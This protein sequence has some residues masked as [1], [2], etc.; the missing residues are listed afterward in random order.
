MAQR[1]AVASSSSLVSMMRTWTISEC[2]TAAA[3]AVPRLQRRTLTTSSTRRSSA[4]EGV[5]ASASTSAY[6]YSTHVNV[7]SIVPSTFTPAPRTKRP[8]SGVMDYVQHQLRSQFDANDRLTSLFHRRSPNQ[9]PIGSVLIVETWS[10]PA[11]TGVTTFSGVLLGVRRRGTSTSFVLRNL[12]QKLG[13]EVRFNLYS[14]L[15]KDVRVIARA[16]AGKGKKNLPAGSIRRVRRAKLYY[17]RK[18]DNKIAGIGRMIKS[19]R[20]QDEKSKMLLAE[21]SAGRVPK[22]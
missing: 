18:D 11:K 4:D 14:P 16:D 1:N 22:Q 3:S 20:Q 10:S 5:G 12:V 7:P 9:I 17:L 8:T 2:S 21:G 6:P 13:V 15:L 19:R